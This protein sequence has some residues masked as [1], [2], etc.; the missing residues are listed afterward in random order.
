MSAEASGLG[1]TLSFVNLIISDLPSAV[2]AGSWGGG[3]AANGDM[4]W[5]GT[6]ICIVGIIDADNTMVNCS[7]VTSVDSSAKG[8]S[9]VGVGFV[10]TVNFVKNI[11]NFPTRL[12][13]R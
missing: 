10:C 7:G 1:K 4:S 5:F 6:M 11:A 8:F 3:G 12:G 2:D 13:S 9:S